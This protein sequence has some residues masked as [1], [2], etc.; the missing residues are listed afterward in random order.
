MLIGGSGFSYDPSRLSVSIGGSQC[1]ITS[2]N[3]STIACITGP[4][5]WVGNK[6]YPLSI[7]VNGIHVNSTVTYSYLSNQTAYI[8]S[9][10]PSANLMGG[11]IIQINGTNFDYN[12]SNIQIYVLAQATSPLNFTLAVGNLC[13]VMSSITSMLTCTAPPIVTGS[14]EVVL[15]ILSRGLSMEARPGASAVSYQLAIAGFSPQSVG[16]GEGINMTINGT[17]FPA[18]I[19]E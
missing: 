13:S 12:A 1:T 9:I 10:S 19:T 11:T 7:T 4:I 14:Y 2:S 16:N 8:S 5:S 18:S 17:G 15:Y 6:N 3:V